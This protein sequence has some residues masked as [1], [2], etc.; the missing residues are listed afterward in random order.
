MGKKQAPTPEKIFVDQCGLYFG[1]LSARGTMLA[2]FGIAKR[3]IVLCNSTSKMKDILSAHGDRIINYGV[4]ELCLHILHVKDNTFWETLTN[5][6]NLPAGYWCIDLKNFLGLIKS[7]KSDKLECY[8]NDDGNLMMVNKSSAKITDSNVIGY[9]VNTYHVIREITNWYKQVNQV[10]G[11]E[12]KKLYPHVEQDIPLDL[13]IYGRIYFYDVDFSVFKDAKGN[14]VFKDI[15][16]KQR[17][18]GIDGLTSVSVQAFLKKLPFK[19]TAKF[20]F[21]SVK[22]D[23]VR[24]LGL[25]EDDIVAVRS[26]RPHVLAVP[27]PKEVKIDQTNINNGDLDNASESE[28]ESDE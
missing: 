23:Y 9:P 12:H 20:Y 28:S 4:G 18:V 14:S 24:V 3:T 19:Y 2:Y 15:N 25:Y 10:G 6:L 22:N 16:P 1:S 7:Y 13:K 26:Y 21:W 11:E 5:L 8:L 17:I 27:L